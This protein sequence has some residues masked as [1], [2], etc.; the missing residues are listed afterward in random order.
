[1][2]DLRETWTVG[3]FIAVLDRILPKL[4]RSL[5]QSRTAALAVAAATAMRAVPIRVLGL[6]L[7]LLG[8]VVTIGTLLMT[9]AMSGVALRVLVLG[10]LVTLTGAM[11]TL[12]RRD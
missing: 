8:A 2:I 10:G 3:P 7:M 5:E 1:M 9:E 11:A 4:N 6:I 12:D